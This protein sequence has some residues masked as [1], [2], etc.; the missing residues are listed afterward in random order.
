MKLE[1]PHLILVCLIGTTIASQGT[2]IYTEDFTPAVV[3]DATGTS[4]VYFN[5]SA[6]E[7]WVGPSNL[8]NYNGDLTLDGQGLAGGRGRGAVVWLDPSSWVGS[9]ATIAFDVSGY[10]AI[11]GAETYFQAYYGNGLG[12]ANDAGFD[13]HQ[14]FGVDLNTNARGSATIGTLGARNVIT[15]NGNNAFNFIYSG[16]DWIALAFYTTGEVAS[17]DNINLSVVV[18]EPTTA[19]ALL[20]LVTGAFFRRRRRL[21]G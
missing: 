12:G 6:D 14:G 21:L 4:L 18:P 1:I 10:S 11:V 17:F 2:I 3:P 7:Y 19:L 15:G 13:V 20:G 16:E 9:S 8:V 5:G